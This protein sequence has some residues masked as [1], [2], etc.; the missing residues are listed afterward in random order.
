MKYDKKIK[1]EAVRMNSDNTSFSEIAYTIK[2]K[3]NLDCN[4]ENLRK[5]IGEWVKGYSNIDDPEDFDGV[6]ETVGIDPSKI[7]QYWYKGKHYSINVNGG[8]PISWDDIKSD[9][10]EEMKRYSPEYKNVAPIL[11]KDL[12][13]HLLVID[14]ADIH[15]G[16]LANEWETGDAYNNSIAV[17]RVL[18]GVDTILR[19]SAGFY[20]SQILFI[21]GNDILHI[22][23]PRRTT[24]SGTPQDT[25]GM[26]YSNFLIA[27][28]LYV[29]IIEKLLAYAP[30]HFVFNPSNHDYTNGF[31]LADV[32][33][34]WFH[35]HNDFTS[36]CSTSYRKYY[37]WFDNLIGT[38]HGDGAKQSSLPL[39]M[40]N[41]CKEGWAKTKHRYI[42]T[43]HVHHKTS[44]DYHGVTVESVR[45][46][47]GTD[48]WHHKNGYQH[49]PKAVEGFIHHKSHGQI[50]R[51]TCVFS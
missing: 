44:T 25:D 49:S 4:T 38:T 45:S 5:R 24:T 16:K 17:K 43:H 9:I 14:P 8:K 30:V 18:D 34:T 35:K 32:I 1:E 19:N 10:I 26:W 31:F 12:D 6:I 50:A 11:S 33:S 48:S 47:S 3:Y 29:D 2:E 51:L 27:K 15:I 42:Y 37:V 40:A 22:D 21:G 39:L 41:E 36:D 46:P 20:I 13:G 23:N 28:K 7:K